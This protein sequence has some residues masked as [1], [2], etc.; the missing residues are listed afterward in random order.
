MGWDGMDAA[1]TRNLLRRS[2]GEMIDLSLIGCPAPMPEEQ[3]LQTLVSLQLVLEAKLVVLVGEFEEVEQLGRGL[4]HGEGGVLGV[5]HDDGDAA[6][7]VE[8]EEP[9][10]FLVVGHDV[11]EGGGPFGAVD[12]LQLLQQHL[13]LLAVG[14]RHCD[15]VESL[16]WTVSEAHM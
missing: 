3:P 5:V 16:E 9:F 15:E 10:L 12:D 4:H 1:H 11:E 8:A 14:R 2:L 13:N 6:V 7:G